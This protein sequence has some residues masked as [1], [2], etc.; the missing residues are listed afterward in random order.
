MRVE[1]TDRE[2]EMSL[3]ANTFR[4][5][6]VYLME[7]LVLTTRDANKGHI[8]LLWEISKTWDSLKKIQKKIYSL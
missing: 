8:F 7:K 3:C 2:Q 1:D 6:L 5:H 4:S